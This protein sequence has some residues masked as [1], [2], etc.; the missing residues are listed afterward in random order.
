MF[1]L[2]LPIAGP[3]YHMA[4]FIIIA[5]LGLMAQSLPM[6]WDDSFWPILEDLPSDAH[7]VRF[8]CCTSWRIRIDE[9][10]KSVFCACLL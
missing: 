3:A 4:V 6:A 2:A 9:L 7:S 8:I 10:L 5:Q 1:L